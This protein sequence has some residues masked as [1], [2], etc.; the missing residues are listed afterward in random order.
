MAIQK[1]VEL[2]PSV[3]PSTDYILKVNPSIVVFVAPER[4]RFDY[5]MMFPGSSYYEMGFLAYLSKQGELDSVDELLCV[6]VLN[7]A[8]E[9]LTLNSFLRGA[10]QILSRGGVLRLENTTDQATKR[11]ADSYVQACETEGFAVTLHMA[12]DR[13]QVKRN[14]VQPNLWHNSKNDG[15]SIVATKK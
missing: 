4:A 2:G 11:Y 12:Q 1:L 10:T 3:F 6:N 14:F 9:G 15:F 5:Q 7:S 8:R 13:E